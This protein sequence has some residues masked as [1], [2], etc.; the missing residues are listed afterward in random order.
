[1]SNTTPGG[2]FGVTIV[3]TPISESALSDAMRA[4]VAASGSGGATI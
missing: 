4:I 1:M 2:S 3:D